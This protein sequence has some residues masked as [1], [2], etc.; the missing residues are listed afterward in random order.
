[1]VSVG[2]MARRASVEQ[3][4]HWLS[5]VPDPE[6]PVISITDLGIVREVT[7]EGDILVVTVTPTYS[8]CP[9]TAMINL[10]IEQALHERGIAIRPAH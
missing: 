3:V 8:G 9:A 5:E 2:S 10:D 6:I 7:W 4:R 1:M